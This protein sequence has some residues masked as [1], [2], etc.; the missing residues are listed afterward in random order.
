MVLFQYHADVIERFPQIIA[1]VI[2][3]EG[4][5][6]QRSQPELI[7]LYRQEQQKVLAEIGTGPLSEIETLAAWRKVFRGFGV[8]PT[9]YRSAVEALLRR[10]TKKG[11]IPSINSLVDIANLV[12]IRYRL[13]VAFFDRQ[14]IQ[15]PITVKFSDSTE[16]FTPLFQDE[17]EQPIEGEVI[18][19]DE[20]DTVIARRW[21]WRQSDGSATR[22]DTSAALITIEAQ[23]ESGHVAVESALQDVLG[24]LENY[25]GGHFMSAVLSASNPA[26]VVS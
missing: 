3:A 22:E 18:F 10:L 9:K 25:V 24:L 4:M 12:S 19:A 26:F 17:V 21:C 15:G 7:A 14:H 2:L 11:S 6:N 5:H 16:R 13:P 23:H 1:G 8:N 20:V